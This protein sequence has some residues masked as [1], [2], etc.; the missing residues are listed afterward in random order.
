VGVA[1][2]DAPADQITGDVNE[3]IE[4]MVETGFIGIVEEL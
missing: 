4:E 1:F 3:F 2:D